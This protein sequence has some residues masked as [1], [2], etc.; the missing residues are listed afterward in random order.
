MYKTDKYRWEKVRKA[1]LQSAG[2]SCQIQGPPCTQWADHV[3]HIKPVAL[4]GT[5]APENLQAAC[6][7]CNL[8]KGAGQFLDGRQSLDA[9]PGESSPLPPLSGDYTARHSR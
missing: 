6:R 1:V 9:S 2:Y 7:N 8:L 4:G 5:D 3:D